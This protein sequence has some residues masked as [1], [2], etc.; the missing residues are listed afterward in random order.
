MIAVA[1][2]PVAHG[3]IFR[4]MINPTMSQKKRRDQLSFVTLIHRGTVAGPHQ[5][6]HRFKGFVGHPNWCQLARPKQAREAFRLS[7]SIRS[8]KRIG[9]KEGAIT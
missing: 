3:P 6:P 8:P 1:Q 7:V 4:A 9:I 5:I 2:A